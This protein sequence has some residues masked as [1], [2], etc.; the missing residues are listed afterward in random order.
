[1]VRVYG[2]LKKTVWANKLVESWQL[3]WTLQGRLRRDG[4]VV[5]LTVEFCTGGCEDG[6]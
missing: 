4:A 2:V 6:T 1:V 5:E 3:S